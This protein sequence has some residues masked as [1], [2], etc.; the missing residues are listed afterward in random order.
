MVS[1]SDLKVKRSSSG[2][3]LFALRAIKKGETII[4][5][6]GRRISAKDSLGKSN[7]YIFN[8]SRTVDIDGSPRFNTARYINHSCRPNCEAINKK[9]QIFIVAKKS[10]KSGE[11]LSYNYGRE[12]FNEYIKPYSCRCLKCDR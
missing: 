11:E 7:R 5:Y 10:I 8:V 3:G 2:L 1:S 6:V 12:Y 4:E 9:G